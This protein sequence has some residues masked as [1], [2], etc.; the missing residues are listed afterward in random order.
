MGLQ[1]WDAWTEGQQVQELV[2]LVAE[3]PVVP[4]RS[5]V[6]QQGQA[7]EPVLLG[8]QVGQML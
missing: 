1:V 6:V 2:T 5:V 3:G 7:G 8:P 4:E